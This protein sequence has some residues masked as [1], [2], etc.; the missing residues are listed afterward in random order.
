MSEWV[1]G[2]VCMCITCACVC[3]CGGAG[4]NGML[5]IHKQQALKCAYLIKIFTYS[6]MQR[7]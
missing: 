6:V 2:C 5:H 4:D 3:V 1:G 7:F